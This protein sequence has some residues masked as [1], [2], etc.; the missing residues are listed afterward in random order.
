MLA[1][2]TCL[3]AGILTQILA[4]YFGVLGLTINATPKDKDSAKTAVQDTDYDNFMVDTWAI[5]KGLSTYATVA[6][7]SAVAC[8]TI[9]KALFRTPRY[10]KLL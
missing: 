6:W 3:Y 9:A 2:L 8:A 10:P 4:Q 7:A 5:G 1:L